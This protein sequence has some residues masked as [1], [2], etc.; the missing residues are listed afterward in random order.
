MRIE[1]PTERADAAHRAISGL[2]EYRHWLVRVRAEAIAEAYH[3]RVPYAALGERW[4]VSGERVRQMMFQ[5]DEGRS[6]W[7]VAQDVS[8]RWGQTPRPFPFGVVHAMRATEQVAACGH[9][10]VHNLGSD[11]TSTVYAACQE[12]QRIVGKSVAS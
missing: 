9:H 4:G 6:G 7:Y 11:F 2:Q 3:Q 5:A 8:A 10:P 1:N 12:C